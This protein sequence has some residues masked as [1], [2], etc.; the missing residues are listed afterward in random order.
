MATPSRNQTETT[1]EHDEAL[2]RRH[3]VLIV[4]GCA[5]RIAPEL[6]DPLYR[7]GSTLL[8]GRDTDGGDPGDGKSWR[9]AD[10]L[11]SS[12]HARITRSSRGVEIHDLSST[13]GT[14]VNGRRVQR[15]TE[16]ADGDL[17]FV[18]SHTA[19]FRFV[20]QQQL[21]AIQEEEDAPLGPVGTASPTL[22]L[23]C[24]K[25]KRLA[26][27]GA[28]ILLTGETGVGKEV[29]AQAIHRASGRQGPFLAINCAAL[30]R[31]LV[32]SELFGYARGAH[33]QAAKSK[34]GLLQEAAGGTV[35]LDEVGEMPGD[36]QAKLL[37]FLQTRT[38]NAL[39]AT[40]PTQIDVRVLAAT[41]RAFL[42]AETSGLRPDLAARLGAQPVKLPALR[43]RVEDLAR[44]ASHFIRKNGPISLHVA[45]FRALCL[46]RWPG[47]VRELEKV[48]S[49]A[50]LLS[51]DAARIGLDHLPEGLSPVPAES[52]RPNLAL[53]RHR[54][55]EAPPRDVLEQLLTTHQGNVAE[56]A[57]SLD[58]Q[59]AVVWR[60][61]VRH[62][63]EIER[64]RKV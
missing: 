44:L 13:N 41:N 29:Y 58:R 16:L 26:P 60:C 3:P 47:N 28:E 37:R 38:F 2:P 55:R 50:I 9:P 33:S 24:R 27:S 1:S 6:A 14:Y 63:I 42:S 10:R 51:R 4:V 25:L 5:D 62:G 40:A 53:Q 31:E 48:L 18:G 11:V 7:V 46:Y 34:R 12:E 49:E 35:F 54:R 64:F 61:I 59:W 23:L 30:P 17:I 21:E 22:A 15:S 19:V 36:A 39:G 56:V 8:I 57:R 32:E 20:T 52:E 45:A 43:D